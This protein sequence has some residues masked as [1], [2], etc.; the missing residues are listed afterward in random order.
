MTRAAPK[1][2]LRILSGLHAGAHRLLPPGE[3]VLG[4]GAGCDIILRDDD[5]AERHLLLVLG[6][7]TAY[8]KRLADVPWHCGGKEVKASRRLL[9]ER[10]VISFG[11]VQISL[12]FDDAASANVMPQHAA[13]QPQ[14]G[15]PAAARS[16]AARAHRLGRLPLLSISVLVA[17]AGALLFAFQAA[18]SGV[19]ERSHSQQLRAEAQRLIGM[20]NLPDLTVQ[21]DGRGTLVL[22]GHVASAQDAQRLRSQSLLYSN[23]TPVMKFQIATELVQHAR[24]YLDDPGLTV[25]YVG[26]GRLLVSGHS[27]RAET[28]ARKTQLIADLRGVVQIDVIASMM[29]SPQP[30]PGALELPVK[31]VGIYDYFGGNA[32]FRA[33]DGTHYQEGSLLKNGAEVVSISSSQVTFRQDGKIFAY[34]APDTGVNHD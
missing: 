7:V 14:R 3:Y 25:Q 24:E 34:H 18:L 17:V 27:T 20:M 10:D 12:Q 32:Y 29:D 1:R 23:G 26:K 13:A 33:D 6:E 28:Q 5:V 11:P 9:S 8:A 15:A 22:S 30:E 31:V 4:S 19:S 21:T 2:V 16:P